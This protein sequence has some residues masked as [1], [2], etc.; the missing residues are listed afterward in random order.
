MASNKFM[1]D[2]DL[3]KNELL[4][5]VVQRLSSAPSNP[6]IG[7]IYFNT[8]DKIL[9]QC[10][11]TTPTVEWKAVGDVPITTIKR[12]GVVLTI[13]GKAVDIEV[14]EDVSDLTDEDNIYVSTAGDTMSGNL[15]MGSHKVTGLADPTADDD[16]VNK[17]YVDDAIEALGHFMEFKGV[18]S[19]Y[20]D[21][22]TTDVKVGDVWLVTADN[23]EY[24]AKAITPEIQ[25]EQFGKVFP[26][27]QEAGGTIAIGDT[28]VT[29]SGIGA[30]STITSVTILDGNGKEVMADVTR[31]TGS[32]TVAFSKAAEEAFTVKVCYFA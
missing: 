28:S 16:A 4:N 32:V 18:K 2:L 19:T 31:G 3:C 24:I 1:A 10:V 5:A 30:T 8:G 6:V 15:A 20:A 11:A 7:Q 9:Y 12:N 23:T 22:P 26:T 21:L 17:G 25:W 14:P 13:V 29:I 27:M